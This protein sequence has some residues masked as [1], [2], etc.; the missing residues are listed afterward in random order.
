MVAQ[1]ALD[2]TFNSLFEMHVWVE[3]EQYPPYKLSILYLRC[4]SMV[5][6]AEPSDLISNLSILYLRCMERIFVPG[7]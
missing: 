3:V 7:I 4:F 6:P 5:T 2:S 1:A